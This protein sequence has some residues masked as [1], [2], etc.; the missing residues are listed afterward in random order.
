VDVIEQIGS[1]L[2]RLRQ[3]LQTEGE[4]VV[5]FV[6]NLILTRVHSFACNFPFDQIFER[7]RDDTAK[8]AA[9]ETDQAAVAG[10]VSQLLQCV[11]HRMP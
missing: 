3:V 4:R 9:E 11:N 7:F 8:R 10:V 6:G 2:E 5:N 1:L